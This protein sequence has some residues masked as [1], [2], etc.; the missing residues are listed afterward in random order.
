VLNFWQAQDRARAI[1]RAGNDTTSDRPITVGEALDNYAA[2]LASRMPA[3][4]IVFAAI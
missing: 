2:E 3:T 4:S 1:A